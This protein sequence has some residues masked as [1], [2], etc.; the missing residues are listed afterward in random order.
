MFETTF[1]GRGRAACA[2][3]ALT[4]IALFGVS[5]ATSGKAQ[6]AD[7]MTSDACFSAAAWQ[8]AVAK[9]EFN[10]G[11]WFRTMSQQNFVDAKQ[12]GD[13]ATFAFYAGNAT[14]AAWYKGIADDY[15]RK[16]QDNARAAD[17]AFARAAFISAAADGSFQ[18]GLFIAGGVVTNKDADDPADPGNTDGCDNDQVAACTASASH[19]C[20]KKKHA[21]DNP[22]RPRVGGKP[23]YE[24]FL[25]LQWCW[26]NDHIRWHHINVD[27]HHITDWGRHIGYV[28]DHDPDKKRNYCNMSNGWSEQCFI[29]YQF[30]FSTG[31]NRASAA[32]GCVETWIRAD[33]HHYRHKYGGDCKDD[34]PL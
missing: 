7:C 6:A 14:A 3:V 19:H 20:T 18:R 16:A 5:L 2:T 33:G 22:Y 30:G 25:K 17:A 28:N 31:D 8:R 15:A 29:R 21:L 1:I 13:K 26:S 32:G 24:G 11:V 12:W 34:F 10:R 4:L 9:D 23:V 27:D